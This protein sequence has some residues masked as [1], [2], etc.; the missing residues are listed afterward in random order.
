VIGRAPVAVGGRA[1]EGQGLVQLGVEGRR[2]RGLTGP[3]F[4]AEVA[5][6]DVSGLRR[7]CRLIVIPSPLPPS[8][9]RSSGQTATVNTPQWTRLGRLPLARY[10]LTP[11]QFSR[12]FQIFRGRAS[13]RPGVITYS[14]H[15]SFSFFYP[16]HHPLLL[17]S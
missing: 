3:E 14:G 17:L 8:D 16:S 6:A 7:R 13:L 5:A 1:D 15:L 12:R 10:G 2:R 11:R 4:A 9:L